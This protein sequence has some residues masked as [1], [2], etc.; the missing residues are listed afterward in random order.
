MK[1]IYRIKQRRKIMNMLILVFQFVASVTLLGCILFLNILPVKYYLIIIPVLVL[2]FLFSIIM[3]TVRPKYERNKKYSIKS[4]IGRATSLILSVLMIVL[5]CF[6][7]KGADFINNITKTS[8]NSNVISVYALNDNNIDS[9]EDL[10]GKRAGM[11]N[12]VSAYNMYDV[13]S[14]LEENTGSHL[15][16][17]LYEDYMTLTDALYDNKIDYIVVDQSY[18]DSIKEKYKDF[19]EDVKLVYEFETDAKTITSTVKVTKESFI[20]YLTGIDT[21]GTVSTISRSDVNL[22][23]CVNPV[24]NQILIV[25]IPRDVKINLHHNGKMDKI[26]HSS[27]YGVNETINTIEDF[28][29]VD[30][31][32]Y[33]KTNFDGIVNIIDALGGVTVE[34]DYEF[35]TLHGNYSI[36]KGT[37]NLNGDQALCFV[38][39][40][41]ALPNGD[42]D[43]GRNQQ[44]L[45][46]A[47]LD[48]T[49]SPAIIKNYDQILTSVEGSFETSL[50]VDDIKSLIN[51][52]LDN[53]EGWEIMSVQ[54]SGSPEYTYE[55]FSL[56]GQRS[57]ITVPNQEKLEKIKELINQIQNGEKIDQ[58]NI[59]K[60][61]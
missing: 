38:R 16:K 29:D 12:N 55:T 31:N 32:Y 5:T 51:M 34:S 58:K 56:K 43:R 24:E 45:L 8:T 14:E 11:E 22:L 57:Y 41:Y 13:F 35:T 25:S 26:T 9:I 28:L 39:E 30:V 10:T 19:D 17:S 49:M 15:E 33:A 2:L 46:K 47:L 4:I 37:N 27:I 40:R 61:N 60:I 44:K 7:T 6:I 42:Y 53:M 50:S 59:E 3:A 21:Y 23:A 52:Q 54:V 20:V 18:K 48:K 1:N 36:K